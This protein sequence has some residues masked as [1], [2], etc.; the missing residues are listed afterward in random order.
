MKRAWRWPLM[1]VG[2]I[3]G[4]MTLVGVTVYFATNDPSAAVEPDYYRKAVAWDDK[5][6]ERSESERL[7]WSIDVRLRGGEQVEFTINDRDGRPVSG[8]V[9]G[10]LAFAEARASQRIPLVAS[11]GDAGRYIAS[12]KFSRA[13]LWRFEIEA[14][15]GTERFI[16]TSQVELSTNEQPAR[17]DDARVGGVRKGGGVRE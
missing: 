5:A 1:V 6:R 17:G 15:R 9:L 16:A 7:G 3:G 8:A 2:L 12:V 4:N 13:G 11:E 10:G 14:T